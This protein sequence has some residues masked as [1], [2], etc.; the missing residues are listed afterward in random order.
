MAGGLVQ[1]ALVVAQCREGEGR[2]SGIKL[3][4]LSTGLQRVAKL[5]KRRKGVQ[6]Y[7]IL[8]WLSSS[9]SYRVM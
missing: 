6:P 5:A 9:H 2:L 3:S 4:A 8:Y 7:I 1:M